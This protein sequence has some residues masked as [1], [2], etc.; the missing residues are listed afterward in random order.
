MK[1]HMTGGG[2]SDQLH[3]LEALQAREQ[4]R[5]LRIE[6]GN[7]IAEAGRR[8]ANSCTTPWLEFT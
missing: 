8:E 2:R 3:A 4:R 1:R 7:V 6:Q 5:L